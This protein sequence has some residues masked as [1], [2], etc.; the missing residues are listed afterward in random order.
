MLIPEAIPEWRSSAAARTVAVTG[1][2]TSVRP[3]PKTR[4]AGS[5]PPRYRTP[6]LEPRQQH[7]PGS[8]HEWADGQRDPRADPLRERPERAE[9][10]SISA[11]T[12][13]DAAPASI[14]E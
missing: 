3:A 11:V 9:N 5:T 13:S 1:A 4:T 14:G 2:T 8:D 10:T 6:G 7:Q 12:G